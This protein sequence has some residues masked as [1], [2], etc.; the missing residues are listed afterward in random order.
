MER[1]C[2]EAQ[3]HACLAWSSVLPREASA[4]AQE[5]TIVYYNILIFTVYYTNIYS[6][7]GLRSGRKGPTDLDFLHFDLVLAV[8]YNCHAFSITTASLQC[9]VFVVEH[10]CKQ[11]HAL[12]A[13]AM[14]STCLCIL[15]VLISYIFVELDRGRHSGLPWGV[16]GV[17]RRSSSTES[18][19]QSSNIFGDNKLARQPEM[20]RGQSNTTR[21]LSSFCW[22]PYAFKRKFLTGL[23]PFWHIFC[24]DTGFVHLPLVRLPCWRYR[25]KRL[26]LLFPKSPRT[27]QSD[28]FP[29]SLHVRRAEY[30]N[31]SR[32]RTP[33][34]ITITY[35]WDCLNLNYIRNNH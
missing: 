24:L 9:T 22:F 23:C 33:R 13:M 32:A 14:P 10:K 5:D 6:I 20:C 26:I 1:G 21:A 7:W 34:C 16:A 31:S 30:I 35:F 15:P 29:I 2:L 4:N 19:S 27:L 8:R 11:M 12:V 3:D 17:T 28:Y 18:L 25:W